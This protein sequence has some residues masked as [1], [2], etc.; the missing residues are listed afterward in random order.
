[1]DKHIAGARD[2]N[3]ACNCSCELLEKGDHWVY[4]KN[5]EMK[6]ETEML[7]KHPQNDPVDGRSM[8]SSAGNKR[9]K[10]S[11]SHTVSH[12]YFVIDVSCC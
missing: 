5:R 2:K 9:K 1:M 3:G 11:E 8:S 6:Q 7:S 12:Q 10:K 4:C